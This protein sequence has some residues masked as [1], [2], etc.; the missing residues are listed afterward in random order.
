MIESKT[1]T[2]EQ[3]K[4]LLEE[5]FE[6]V[7]FPDADFNGLPELEPEKDDEEPQTVT[8]AAKRSSVNEM[9]TAVLLEELRKRD[10]SNPF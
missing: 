9:D 10:P 8:T 1:I 2:A 4:A 7:D 5:W 3:E 6:T